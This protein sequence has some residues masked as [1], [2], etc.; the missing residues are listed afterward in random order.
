MSKNSNDFDGLLEPVEAIA[1]EQFYHR[2]DEF[3]ALANTLSDSTGDEEF[4]TSASK[5]S[6]SLM[7]ANARFN[8]WLTACG[9][10]NAEDLKANKEQVLSYFLEQYKLMLEDNFDEYSNNFDEYMNP[11]ED[12]VK[13][14]V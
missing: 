11:P 12:E 10:H 4:A 9:Y 6:A 14:F 5:V 1:D 8:I 3:I 2:A 13:H 7:Y